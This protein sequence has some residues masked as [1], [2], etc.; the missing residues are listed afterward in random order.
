MSDEARYF[1]I[2]LRRGKD[3]RSAPLSVFNLA[4]KEEEAAAQRGWE[5]GQAALAQAQAVKEAQ[6]KRDD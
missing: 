5:A 1:K 3:D 6:K 2:G 4:N